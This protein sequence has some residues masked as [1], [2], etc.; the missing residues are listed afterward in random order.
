MKLKAQR[1]LLHRMVGLLSPA[2]KAANDPMETGQYIKIKSGDNVCLS[3]GRSDMI[4]KVQVGQCEGMVVNEPGF[5]IVD[6]NKLCTALGTAVNCVL[7]VSLV[8]PA[9]PKGRKKAGATASPVAASPDLSF[10][11]GGFLSFKENAIEGFELAC[12]NRDHDA[13]ISR[14]GDNVVKMRGAD[15]VKYVKNM[16]LAIGLTG[17]SEADSTMLIR[18]KDEGL[19]EM[20]TTNSQG[21]FAWA[22]IGVEASCKFEA[23]VTYDLIEAIAKMV[24]VTQD[25][26]MEVSDK[27]VVTQQ[28][29]HGG[30]QVGD[31]MFQV[32]T[33]NSD[34]P[35]FEA[36]LNSLHYTRSFKMSKQQGLAAFM[37]MGLFK[38]SQTRMT[39]DPSKPNVVLTKIDRERGG[40][41]TR[42]LPLMEIKGS[43]LGDP[44]EL[45]V[46]SDH[47]HKALSMAESAEPEMRLSGEH[48]IGHLKMDDKMSMFFM[49]FAAQPSV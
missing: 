36:T 14:G 28:F 27:I 35:D 15:F 5:N 39:F 4:A 2:I 7:D 17:G 20:A 25:L 38:T 33:V 43:T 37:T 31:A 3:I 30:A 47:F 34:F 49:P 8:T 45:D 48:S 21:Q 11:T 6:G 41:T 42:M 12:S 23:F 29:M 22:K 24:D 46:A 1:S 18:V 40:T 26:T 16:R 10:E 32:P 44:I 13:T 19:L 9:A